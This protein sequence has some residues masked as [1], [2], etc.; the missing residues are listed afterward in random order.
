MRDLNDAQIVEGTSYTYVADKS[1]EVL[2]PVLLPLYRLGCLPLA[3]RNVKAELPRWGDTLAMKL[4]NPS[5]ELYWF[6]QARRHFNKV[7]EK[8]V[9]VD[10]CNPEFSPSHGPRCER[11]DQLVDLSDRGNSPSVIKAP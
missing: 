6:R 5:T 2:R 4:R 8:E 9:C 7:A 1:C 10:G 3:V 11:R